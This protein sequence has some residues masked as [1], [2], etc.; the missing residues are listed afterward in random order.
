VA[1]LEH[2]GDRYLSSYR[3]ASDWARNL[4]ASHRG[5]LAQRRRAEEI[6]V[7]EVPVD[8]RGPLLQVYAERFGGMPTVGKV[9]RA[10]PDPAD[11][12]TFQI[13]MAVPVPART[14]TLPRLG[15]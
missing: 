1:V 4:A 3:G 5:R 11:H 2:D 10:L 12:P 7:E 6:E 14:K 15:R 8:E 13:T 9:L